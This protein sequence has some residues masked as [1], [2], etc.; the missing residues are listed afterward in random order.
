MAKTHAQH[1]DELKA[2]RD[3]IVAELKAP[4]SQSAYGGSPDKSG[5]VNVQR[6]PARAQLLSELRE[7][8]KLI[9]K[10]ETFEVTSEMFA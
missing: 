7:V 10:L 2:W 4:G 1:L 6:M 5:P 9:A 8:E 3:A